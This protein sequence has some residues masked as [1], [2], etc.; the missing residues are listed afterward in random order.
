MRRYGR[1][2]SRLGPAR[3]LALIAVAAAVGS[4]WADQERAYELSQSGEIL[5]LSN[6]IERAL[7]IAPGTLLEAELE[8]QNGGYVY[9]IEL[10]TSDG[11]YVEFHFDAE[12]GELLDR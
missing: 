6:I 12:T 3:I 4:A 1:E 9:E 11:R 10:A 5:P 7:A 8:S 2:H